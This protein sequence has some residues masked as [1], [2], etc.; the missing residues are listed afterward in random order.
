MTLTPSSADIREW[1]LA[2]ASARRPKSNGDTALGQV[3][4]INA[5][6][7]RLGGN[8]ASKATQEAVLTEWYGLFRSGFFAWGADLNNPSPPFFH[9][10]DKGARSLE[11]IDRDPGNPAGYLR[12]LAVVASINPV[13][14]SYLGEGLECFVAGH[15]KAA[16]VMVGCA[17][18]S[19]VLD[20]RDKLVTRLRDVGKP[21]PPKMSDWQIKSV[22]DAMS[23]VFESSKGQ[24]TRELRESFDSRWR[25]FAHQI[26]TTR[27]DAGHPTSVDSVKEADV[28]AAFLVFPSL[29]ELAKNLDEWVTT[30]W[31]GE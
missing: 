22:L 11:R 10:T 21:V 29:A 5:L 15:Y 7:Q 31:S 2:E 26:R 9:F 13:S 3:A 17:A 27:N 19:L 25:A 24:F 14:E 23:G 18:E 12:H 8:S 1:I 4:I 6:K 30:A 16:A 20:L 28:H